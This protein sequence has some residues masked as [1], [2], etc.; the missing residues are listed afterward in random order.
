MT[1]LHETYSYPYEEDEYHTFLTNMKFPFSY[2]KQAR[3]TASN[4]G[5]FTV[6][7]NAMRKLRDFFSCRGAH[8][9]DDE[10]VDGDQETLIEKF[11]NGK[12][13]EKMPKSLPT[14]GL[15]VTQTGECE[16]VNGRQEKQQKTNADAKDLKKGETVKIKSLGRGSLRKETSRYQQIGGD[17][18]NSTTINE[19]DGLPIP[20]QKSTLKRKRGT[21]EIGADKTGFDTYMKHLR[22]QQCAIHEGKLEQVIRPG[23]ASPR[24]TLLRPPPPLKSQPSTPQSTPKRCKDKGA[25]PKITSNK[26]TSYMTS[27]A[28]LLDTTRR[29]LTSNLL[30][31][32]EKLRPPLGGHDF[33]YVGILPRDNATDEDNDDDDD[34]SFYCIGISE[35]QLRVSTPELERARRI[36]GDGIDLWTEAHGSRA[37][38]RMCHTCRPSVG[39]RGLCRECEVAFQRS[40]K[41][42][43]RLSQNEA[44]PPVPL[45]TTKNRTEKRVAPSQDE[46]QPS[47]TSSNDSEKFI[48]HCAV[49]TSTE[50]GRAPSIAS[51]HGKIRR[52]AGNSHTPQRRTEFISIYERWQTPEMRAELAKRAAWRWSSSLVAREDTP[53][54][55]TATT[56][57]MKPSLRSKVSSS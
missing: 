1:E 12:M 42:F 6:R 52:V 26:L 17:E 32:V 36:S 34:Q 53:T 50:L 56:I 48:D 25:T 51:H 40:M 30:K 28:D 10:G 37:E 18:E 14:D 22:A 8:Q 41:S 16:Q 3:N 31:S 19:E 46:I 20:P 4:G 7:P 33:R 15:R 38:C 13:P 54:T 2:T 21:K 44:K 43:N 11:L 9:Q 27:S 47:P 24:N 57:P 49:R 23:Y 39:R 55:T 45:Q 35:T 29:D 5:R